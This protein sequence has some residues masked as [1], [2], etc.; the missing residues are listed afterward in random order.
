MTEWQPIETAP[1]NFQQI[2]VYIP[3]L[4]D[5]ENIQIA[6]NNNGKWENHIDST[7]EL[8]PTHW[9]PLPKIQHICKKGSFT[10]STEK[11]VLWLYF[12]E[13][14]DQL[15]SSVRS[16]GIQINYCPICGEKA[17]D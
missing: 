16:T 3:Y 7:Y 13:Y 15:P 9:M 6:L 12:R 17:N 2:L 4:D 5:P 10:C 14:K 8:K 1:K 11:K